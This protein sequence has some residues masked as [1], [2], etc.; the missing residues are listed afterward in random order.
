MTIDDVCKMVVSSVDVEVL[1][2]IVVDDVSGIDVSSAT[3]VDTDTG[4]DVS[5]GVEVTVISVVLVG[6]VIFKKI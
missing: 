4:G 2:V 1:L 6:S 5:R 3:V